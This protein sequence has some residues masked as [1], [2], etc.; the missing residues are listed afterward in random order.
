MCKSCQ[1]LI[2][3]SC[4]CKKEWH[5]SVGNNMRNADERFCSRCNHTLNAQ[6]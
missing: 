2:G 4:Y 3:C 5:S 6:R 1:V